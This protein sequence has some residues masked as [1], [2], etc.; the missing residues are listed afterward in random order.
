[1]KCGIASLTV[2]AIF[3]LHPPG[4]FVAADEPVVARE[5]TPQTAPQGE[6]AP[7]VV[8]FRDGYALRLV[9]ED[10]TVVIL[11][12]TPAGKKLRHTGPLTL[13]VVV[14]LTAQPMQKCPISFGYPLYRR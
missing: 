7:K 5:W 8:P 2:I 10:K 9:V 3:V 1:M 12:E 11:S 4:R 13:A 6:R 14:Q